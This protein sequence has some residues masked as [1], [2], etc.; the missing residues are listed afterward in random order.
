MN[1]EQVMRPFPDFG[2]VRDNA[3]AL[4]IAIH[5]IKH[6]D[7]VWGCEV[8]V[9]LRDY[10]GTTQEVKSLQW[11]LPQVEAALQRFGAPSSTPRHSAEA[12]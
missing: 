1:E 6:G 9:R 11:L 2:D 5:E 4:R 12:Y 3:T 8:L 10:I 7:R